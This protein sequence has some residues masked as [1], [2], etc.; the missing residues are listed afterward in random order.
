LSYLH[1]PV[2]TLVRSVAG[3]GVLDKPEIS[4]HFF[5]HFKSAAAN[6]S[7]N[8]FK[9]RGPMIGAVTAG[10]A[11]AQATAKVQVSHYVLVHI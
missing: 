3:T 5:C 4:V 9:L 2:N 6:E 10:L 8:W 1:L 11:I 7:S